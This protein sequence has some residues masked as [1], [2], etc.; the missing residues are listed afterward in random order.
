[1]LRDACQEGNTKHTHT[2]TRGWGRGKSHPFSISIRA[3][4]GDLNDKATVALRSLARKSFH[5]HRRA[6]MI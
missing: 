3:L 6:W 5:A 4:Q 2:H 1:M